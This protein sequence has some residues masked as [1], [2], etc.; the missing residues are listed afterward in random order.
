MKTSLLAIPVK[1]TQEVDWAKPLTSYLVS[2][3]GSA[4]EYKEDISQFNKLRNDIIGVHHDS[5]GIKLYYKYFSKLELI[6]LRIPIAGLTKKIN[7]VWFDAFDS[8]EHKQSAIPFEKA[9]ILFNLGALLASYGNSKYTAGEFKDAITLHQQAAGVF[10]FLNENFLHA[11]SEDLSQTTV[12][13]LIQ[14]LLAQSQEIFLLKVIDDDL[15]QKKNSLIAKLCS[16]ASSLFSDCAK[17]LVEGDTSGYSVEDYLEQ[18]ED[19]SFV[20][21]KIDPKWKSTLEFKS[22]F[23]KSLSYYYNGLALESSKKYGESIGNLNKSK[24]SLESLSVPEDLDYILLENYDLQKENLNIKLSLANKDNDLVYNELIPTLIPDIKPMNSA[25]VIKIDENETFLQTNENS[26]LNFLKN[27][28]PINIHELLSYYSEEKAQFLRN[29]IDLV[30]VSNEE[31][32]SILDYYKL[33]QSLREEKVSVDEDTKKKCEEIRQGY[34]KEVNAKRN[35]ELLRQKIYANINGDINLKKTLYDA[36]NS[37]NQLNQL[38]QPEKQLYDNII[39]NKIFSQSIS[40]EISLLDL[41]DLV[42]VITKEI[43]DHLYELNS[44]K[45]SKAK[46]I[47]KLKK[48]IHND[49]ISDIL[50]FNSKKSSAEIKNVIFPQELK[51]FEP[52]TFELNKLVNEQKELLK[53]IKDKY[54]K[55]QNNSQ[56]KNK[57]NNN[58]LYQQQLTEQIQDVNRFYPIWQKYHQGVI[59]GEGFYEKL[60]EYSKR[61]QVRSQQQPGYPNQQQPGY[62]SPIQQQYSGQSQQRAPQPPPIQPQSTNSSTNSNTNSNSIYDQPSTYQPNMYNFFSKQ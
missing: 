40:D 25:K 55:F 24:D 53:L 37:D 1:T 44:I 58:R 60:F 7:F 11:P 54:S 8:T 22:G 32:S 41:D 61:N 36:T 12:K 26:S 30:D 50:I 4:S 42:H 46:L 48:A 6:D 49:D 39:L 5:K 2:I 35:I 17:L 9:N 28:V 31:M 27:V 52:A 47:E 33:P 59:R 19:L 34:Q 29:E 38:I 45:I 51:K 15:E 23:Y 18:P 20:S 3:Y 62:S 13:F 56:V 43:E 57:A 14:L 16:A 21:A 10:Q